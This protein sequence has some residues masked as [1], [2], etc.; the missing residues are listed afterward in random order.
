M[1]SSF[2]GSCSSLGEING[3]SPSSAERLNNLAA[4]F[5]RYTLTSSVCRER[6]DVCQ[7]KGVLNACHLEDV[8][9]VSW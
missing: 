6:I 7:E 5:A 8:S 1:S 4:V 2:C 3:S 9:A